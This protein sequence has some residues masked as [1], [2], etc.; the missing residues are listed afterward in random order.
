MLE[1]ELIKEEIE[2]VNRKYCDN[3]RNA[4]S[5]YNKEDQTKKDYN[6]RQLYELLQNADDCFTNDCNEI[7][8]KI[9]LVGN[10]LTIQN[11]GKPFSASGIA[12]L[13]NTNTSTKHGDTIGC[14]G[15]GFRSV[16]NWAYEILQFVQ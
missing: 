4:M 5:D 8:V 1:I 2:S 11:T 14:K 7:D 16:L 12:S 13:I 15:L 10:R 9:N 6:G 3:V